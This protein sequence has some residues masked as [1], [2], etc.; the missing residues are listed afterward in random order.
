MRD[1]NIV[2]L[3]KIIKYSEEIAE[4][5]RILDLDLVKF[6]ENFI[7]KNAISMC[8][9]QIGELAGKLS[10]EFRATYSE[11]PWQYVVAVRNRAAH[12]YETINI[13]VLWDIASND[14]P[15]LKESCEKIILELD[16]Q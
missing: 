11:T 3:K 9:L 8:V 7:A 14:I 15:E 16:K 2:V 10:D 13:D 4:T 12:A 6:R 1:R 5:I